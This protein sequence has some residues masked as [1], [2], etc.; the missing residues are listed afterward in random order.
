MVLTLDIKNVD[1]INTDNRRES[2]WDIYSLTLISILTVLGISQWPYLPRFFDSYYHLSVMLGFNQAG[3]FFTREFLEYA[4][5]GR[6]HIYPPFLHILIVFLYKLGLSKI[7]IARLL[8]FAIYPLTLTVIWQVIKNTFGSRLSF[9]VIL[10]WVSFY[11]LF[12]I[13]S[14]FIPFSLALILVLLSFL[15]LEKNKVFLAGLL[16]GLSFY[17]HSVMSWLSVLCIFLYGALNYIKRSQ[18]FKAVLCGIILGLP[19]LLYQYHNRIY[20][21]LPVFPPNY[22]IQINV[23]VYLLSLIGIVIALRNKGSNYF[24]IC[25]IV[26]MLPLN[27]IHKTRYLNGHGSTGFILA[28]GLAIDYFYQRIVVQKYSRKRLLIFMLV[29][30]S[31]LLV[32]NPTLYVDNGRKKIFMRLFNPAFVNLMPRYKK[33]VYLNSLSAYRQKFMDDIVKVIVRNTDKDDII[34]SNS[35]YRAVFLSVLSER[36]TSQAM[37]REVRAYRDF[38]PVGAARVI[39]WFKETGTVFPEQLSFLIAKYKLYKL[40]ETDSAYVYA[41]PSGYAKNKISRAV[42]ST[43]VLVFIV[44][45]IISLVVFETK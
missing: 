43:P 29:I 10:S 32:F 20:F 30:L 8:E 21:K 42:I 26:A 37:L 38:D 16:L 11:F 6:P 41:N 1:K 5:I 12:G 4:P 27:Y 35:Y 15:C 18:S 36:A 17:T 39:V 45:V 2:S 33:Y 23:L 9:F 40:A 22:I 28:S 25:F 13:I 34:Y 44:L 19:L 24:F 3:G 14:N 7:F 31:A